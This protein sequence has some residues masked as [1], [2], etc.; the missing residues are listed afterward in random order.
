MF[1]MLRYRLH[2][3]SKEKNKKQT[4]KLSIHHDF[5]YIHPRFSLCVV[6]SFLEWSYRGYVLCRVREYR[7]S[8][9]VSNRHHGCYYDDGHNLW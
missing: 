9:W 8:G 1:G 5:Q 7:M 2:K 6:L 3:N 4:T